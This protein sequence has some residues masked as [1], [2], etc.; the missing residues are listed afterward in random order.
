MNGSR[1]RQGV[2]VLCLLAVVSTGCAGDSIGSRRGNCERLLDLVLDG[3]DVDPEHINFA[4]DWG[5]LGSNW[6]AFQEAAR[7]GEAEAAD[8]RLSLQVDLC[9][10][11][12]DR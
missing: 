5:L 4:S 2:A 6:E 12:L 3:E 1:R 8:G 7:N 10:D 9:L 11:Y